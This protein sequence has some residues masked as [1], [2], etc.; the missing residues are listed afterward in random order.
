MG[1]VYLQMAGNIISRLKSEQLHR[2]DI[3]FKINEKNIDTMIGRKA[4][5]MFLESEA[6]MRMLVHCYPQF[7]S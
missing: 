1:G 5:I 4:H 7:F 6:L 3:N 2:L